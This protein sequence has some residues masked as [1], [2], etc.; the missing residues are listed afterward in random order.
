MYKKDIYCPGSKSERIH[1]HTPRSWNLGLFP[2]RMQ[3]N[4]QDRIDIRLDYQLRIQVH[5]EY[6]IEH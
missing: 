6:I 3:D 5:R 2:I 4:Q 1:P